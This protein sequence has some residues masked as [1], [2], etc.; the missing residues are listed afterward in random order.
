MAWAGSSFDSADSY[1]GDG[2]RL[3]CHEWIAAVSRYSEVTRQNG[4]LEFALNTS[5]ATLSAVEGEENVV[6]AQLVES[7]ARVVGKIFKVSAFFIASTLPI[8]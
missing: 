7:D 3:F 1:N 5:Q 2:A 8:F 4:Q 6:R